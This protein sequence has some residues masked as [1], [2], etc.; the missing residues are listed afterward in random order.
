[1][2]RILQEVGVDKRVSFSVTLNTLVV[3][4]C[5]LWMFIKP[6]DCHP[7]LCRSIKDNHCITLFFYIGSLQ[8]LWKQMQQTLFLKRFMWMVEM[9]VIV[10]H[11]H[12]T[13]E[14]PMWNDYVMET[15]TQVKSALK[16][17]WSSFMM[18]ILLLPLTSGFWP[19]RWEFMLIVHRHPW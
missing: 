16:D 6:Q 5:S 15:M 17:I 10:R 4:F 13:C 9:E 7:W 3:E 1:M 18:S 14:F 19:L 11:D 8:N 2:S 12:P